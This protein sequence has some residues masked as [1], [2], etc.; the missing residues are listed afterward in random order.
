MGVCRLCGGEH[1]FRRCVRLCIGDIVIDC[2]GEKICLLE[3][4]AHILAQ[5]ILVII[6]DIPA[7]Y[8]D[9]S[10][11]DIIEAHDKVYHSGLARSRM[12]DETY[13]LA[14]FYLQ[15]YILEHRLVAFIA[16]ADGIELN[17]ARY[18]I[19]AG[20]SRIADLRLFIENLIN[21]YKA[22]CDLR[23]PTR[24]IGKPVERLIDIREQKHKAPQLACG[25]RAVYNHS[26]AEIEHEEIAGVHKE[27]YNREDNRPHSL[28]AH[29]DIGK[30][31][32][33]GRKLFNLAFFAAECFDNTDAFDYIVK[34][35][36]RAAVIPP[37]LIIAQINIALEAVE[38]D[39]AKRRRQDCEKSQQRAHAQH[40]Y[41][42]D[43][44]EYNLFECIATF[45]NKEVLHRVC[46]ARNTFYKIARSFARHGRDGHTLDFV[47]DNGAQIF[48]ESESDAVRGASREYLEDVFEQISQRHGDADN[49]NILLC[50]ESAGRKR[51]REAVNKLA[52][53]HRLRRRHKICKSDEHARHDKSRHKL[54]KH[55]KCSAPHVALINAEHT[56]IGAFWIAS[57][58]DRASVGIVGAELRLFACF[59]I[60]VDCFAEFTYILS[61]THGEAADSD[62][63]GAVV[64]RAELIRKRRYL[65]A[66]AAD[67]G[68]LHKLADIFKRMRKHLFAVL[69][70]IDC[71]V[72]IPQDTAA[73]L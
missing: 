18:R 10:A 26:A 19:F 64:I 6:A 9:R 59:Y 14:R 42:D 28:V 50:G 46:I 65:E 71:A 69:E 49:N 43:D 13:H 57:A 16:K 70:R 67:I 56:D 31:L 45:I 36:V 22:R 48:R 38:R 44:K 15:I 47:I 20:V 41:A 61:G 60:V 62:V 23:Y 8:L 52:L 4:D 27:A 29:G 12:A 34:N 30:S 25:H 32:A 24:H 17:F 5:I 39:N 53:E 40:E 55:F 68:I 51:R 72:L 66:S 58:A 63:P 33:C 11:V 73:R 21:F 3:H 7:V 1:L 37:L 54:P 35:R 2:A